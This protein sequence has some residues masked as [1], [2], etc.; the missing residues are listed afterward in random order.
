MAARP[1]VL[2]FRQELTL[3]GAIIGFNDIRVF[4]HLVDSQSPPV[5][6]I[7]LGEDSDDEDDLVE[8]HYITL[9]AKDMDGK[10]ILDEDEEDEDEEEEEKG[11]FLESMDMTLS[12]DHRTLMREIPVEVVVKDKTLNNIF[13][14]VLTVMIIVNTVNMGGQLDL[15]VIKEVF[16]RPIGP[17]VGFCSQ[18][19]LMPLVRDR[20]PLW[21]IGISPFCSFP[22]ASAG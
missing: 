11:K 9:Q 13:T 18:F 22:T 5:T 6:L 4:G 14:L 1:D 12:K 7:K 2:R 15:N 21:P 8:S 19:M 16:R 17:A 20:F 10:I 3:K